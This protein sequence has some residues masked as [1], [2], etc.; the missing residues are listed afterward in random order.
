M[1]LRADLEPFG[2]EGKAKIVA[3]EVVSLAGF[4]VV[5]GFMIY[6]EWQH[7]SELAR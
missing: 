6:F 4:L 7:L 5:L 1:E 2:H 3:V